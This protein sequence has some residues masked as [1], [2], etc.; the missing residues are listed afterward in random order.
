MESLGRDLWR[1]VKTMPKKSRLRCSSFGFSDFSSNAESA[2]ERGQTIVEFSLVFVLLVVVAW[3]P[4]DFGLAFYT[5]QI[6]LNASREG[7]RIAAAE[8]NPANLVTD[9]CMMPCVGKTGVLRATADR[10]S[11]ALLPGATVSVNLEPGPTCNG[12]VTV[13]IDGEYRYF[14]YNL[15]QLMGFNIINPVRVVRSTSMRWEHQC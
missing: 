11:L 10:M 2:G 14:F 15:L 6:A 4:A 5:G 8:Q 9:S 12:V 7:A 1:R 13:A 3:I